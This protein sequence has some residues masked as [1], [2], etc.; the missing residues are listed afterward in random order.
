M[1]DADVR[2][3]AQRA[4]G[5]VCCGRVDDV[6]IMRLARNEEHS[7]WL[8]HTFSPVCI[9]PSNFFLLSTLLLIFHIGL[10]ICGID[11][12]AALPSWKPRPLSLM[13]CKQTTTITNAYLSSHLLPRPLLHT[14]LPLA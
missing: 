7:V 1:C 13:C 11:I 10:K 3:H 14:P 8:L 9:L 6:S 2:I 4:G 5:W 12:T